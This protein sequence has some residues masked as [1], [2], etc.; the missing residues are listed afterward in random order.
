MS[1][2]AKQLFLPFQGLV[3]VI[4]GLIVLME[5]KLTTLVGP[6]QFFFQKVSNARTI[7]QRIG[8]CVP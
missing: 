8:Q 7:C 2:D 5:V 4:C 6:R 3:W 1:H